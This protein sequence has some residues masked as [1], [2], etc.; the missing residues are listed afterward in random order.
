[1]Q[2]AILGV[3]AVGLGLATALARPGE[4]LLL[5]G[6]DPETARAISREGI[7][8]SGLFGA[9]H[10]LPAEL[11]IELDPGVLVEVAP[12]WLLVCT[13]AKL[14]YYRKESG[15]HKLRRR[16][17]PESFFQYFFS[18]RSANSSSRSGP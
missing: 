6:R 1:M 7:R 17:S 2:I 9:A 13:K 5:I 3:G 11:R 14:Y 15:L 4:R 8:R 10:V 12:D 18:L 16:K